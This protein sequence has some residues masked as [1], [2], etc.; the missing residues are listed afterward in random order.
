MR[1][2]Y[3]CFNSILELSCPHAGDLLMFDKAL[4][5][6]ND[7]LG[8][9]RCRVPYDSKC[10]IDVQNLLNTQCGG[11]TR[12]ALAVNTAVFDDPCGYDEFLYVSYRCLPGIHKHRHR[13]I[14]RC[15]SQLF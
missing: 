2:Q 3:A 1:R 8:S 9:V 14:K 11:K 12:C 15:K 7:T 4:Y 10:E 13:R 6:R 5:G